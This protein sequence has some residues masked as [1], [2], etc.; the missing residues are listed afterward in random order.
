MSV[1][2]YLDY[3]STTPIDPRVKD[4]LVAALG[5][6][7]GNPHSQHIHG[8]KSFAAVEEAREKI[9]NLVNVSPGEVIFTSGATEANNLVFRGLADW[10]KEQG[11]THIVTTATEHKCVLKCVE[12]LEADGFTVSFVPLDADGVATA[13][14]VASTLTENTG[15]VSVMAANNEVGTIHPIHEVG[16]LCAQSDILF[17][18]DAAQAFGKCDL[19]LKAANVSL[20]SF[21]SHKI[22]GPAGIGALYV[23]R[24]ARRKLSPQILGGGQERG[25]RSGTLPVP[26]CIAFGVA[27]E[28]AQ[29]EMIDEAGRVGE[30]RDR[31]L[32]A[33]N[34]QLTGVTING[35]IRSRL[36]GNLNIT[37]EGVD[38]EALV[39]KVKKTISISTGSACTADTLEPSYVLQALGLSRKSAESAIRIGLGRFTTED[40]ISQ[41][42][43][44]L[45]EA[46]NSL[47]SASAEY[48]PHS[49]QTA[50]V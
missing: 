41:A 38:A 5:H 44:V 42:I 28:V 6:E 33:L 7:Y 27:A 17:H 50:S 18:T 16:E 1:P 43:T 32:S 40:D 29:K 47:R 13:E 30:L 37:F 21:S 24:K 48:G 12:W 22:Y 39:M 34:E 23:S 46:V 11:K 19:D 14:S 9:A 45:V 35:G 49:L 10:L 26:L 20:A 31:L 4:E 36:P 8:Q 3:H 2:I 15:L 25:L